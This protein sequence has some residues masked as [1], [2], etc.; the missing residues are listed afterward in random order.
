MSLLQRECPESFTCPEPVGD[1]E[2][3]N[4]GLIADW[5]NLRYPR[6]PVGTVGFLISVDGGNLDARPIG[7]RESI[8]LGRTARTYWIRPRPQFPPIIVPA[9]D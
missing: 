3:R 8:T 7:P 4:V 9:D 1:I 6:T 5:I 2:S